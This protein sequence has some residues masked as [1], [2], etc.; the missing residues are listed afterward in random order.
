[1]QKKNKTKTKNKKKSQKKTHGSIFCRFQIRLRSN[2]FLSEGKE[3]KKPIMYRN[4][5]DYFIC[6]QLEEI[7]IY[8][9]RRY[10]LIIKAVY[11]AVYLV[12]E[13]VKRSYTI[14]FLIYTL[15]LTNKCLLNFV[16]VSPTSA[17]YKY[18]CLN[19]IVISI[20]MFHCMAL[21]FHLIFLSKHITPRHPFI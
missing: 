6:F 3:L 4:N 14:T 16:S 20:L 1:M 13:I 12:G 2:I 5:F 15:I 9:L 11:K 8:T 18:P 17:L 7:M 21:H 10:I 19:R